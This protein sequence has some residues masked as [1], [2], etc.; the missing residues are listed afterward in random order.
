M[1]ESNS[2]AHVSP[3]ILISND[4]TQG[5]QLL[6]AAH[7]AMAWE[8]KYGTLSEYKTENF[9]FVPPA[10]FENVKKDGETLTI[11][12]SALDG[13]KVAL[14]HSDETPVFQAAPKQI[15][16]EVLLRMY[17]VVRDSI[18]AG[19]LFA[20]IANGVVSCYRQFIDD[21]DMKNWVSGSFAKVIV[22]ANEKEFEKAKKAGDFTAIGGGVLVFK[23][24][25]EWDKVFRF[26]KLYK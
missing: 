4:V 19:E 12:E 13:K 17:V 6:A 18:P 20:P 9:D 14:V 10:E 2:S 25:P 3:K 1:N 7:A 26:M 8:L 24:R 5:F 11:T 23:P 22:K 16:L 21:P 15:T